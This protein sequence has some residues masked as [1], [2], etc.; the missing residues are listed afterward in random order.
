MK[1]T[2]RN[3]LLGASLMVLTNPSLATNHETLTDEIPCRVV[4][5]QKQAAFALLGQGIPDQRSQDFLKNGINNIS[6][7]FLFT[8]L[9]HHKIN[10]VINRTN[11]GCERLAL[12]NSFIDKNTY[13][14]DENKNLIASLL[15]LL[16]DIKPA[17]Y[18]PGIPSANS[19][20]HIGRSLIFKVIL[21]VNIEQIHETELACSLL[22]RSAQN[23]HEILNIVRFIIKTP[24]NYRLPFASMC[25]PLIRNEVIGARRIE[26]FKII[27][28]FPKEKREKFIENCLNLDPRS[29]YENKYYN[30]D[31][32]Q[33]LANVPKEER[34]L[35]VEQSRFLSKRASSS[36]QHSNMLIMASLNSEDRAHYA[37]NI[38]SFSEVVGGKR[39]HLWL[40][41][42]K[43]LLKTNADHFVE[44]AHFIRKGIPDYE[45]Y[46]TVLDIVDDLYKNNEIETIEHIR[47]FY[48]NPNHGDVRGNILRPLIKTPPSHWSQIATLAIPL[49][50]TSNATRTNNEVIINALAAVD[51]DQRE[52]I[53]AAGEPLFNATRTKNGRAAIISILDALPA[54][55]RPIFANQCAPL[56][57]D[58]PEGD[59]CVTI[60]N[61]EAQKMYKKRQT[62][63]PNTP[64][65]PVCSSSQEPNPK[66][67]RQS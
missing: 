59:K 17:P 43:D 45:I 13:K 37:K 3:I 29:H 53:I 5:L 65:F 52:A 15:E 35:F 24:E 26:I 7:H 32:L 23:S 44:T 39:I 34:D 14:W 42:L 50:K 58:I 9:H 57:K 62:Q 67:S 60:L 18:I 10:E 11:N 6:D 25:E 2:I 64:T 28:N 40:D 12:L 54:P 21:D 4:S 66:R 46:L 47:L 55:D 63:T 56:I 19:F 27:L 16:N 31:M 41:T 38:K 48:Q 36:T 8:L 22:K 49:I 20:R 51:P 33:C 30:I 1:T 61:K